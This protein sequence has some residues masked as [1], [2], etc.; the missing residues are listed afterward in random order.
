MSA[1]PPLQSASQTPP[2]SPVSGMPA[3]GNVAPEEPGLTRFTV[4]P[5]ACKH[6][7]PVRQVHGGESSP[8]HAFCAQVQPVIVIGHTRE[9]TEAILTRK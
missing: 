9:V 2:W 7:L 4:S 3:S 1:R 8:V 5:A 6:E